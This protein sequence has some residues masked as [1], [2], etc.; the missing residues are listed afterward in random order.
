MTLPGLKSIISSG[1]N[2]QR[3]QECSRGF[4]PFQKDTFQCI[5]TNRNMLWAVEALEDCSVREEEGGQSGFAPE[6]QLAWGTNNF[7]VPVSREMQCSRDT[8]PTSHS[9]HNLCNSSSLVWLSQFPTLPRVT[10][11][12]LLTFTGH[13]PNRG[14]TVLPKTV[15]KACSKA[16]AWSR[17]THASKLVTSLLS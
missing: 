1:C 15:Q 12:L 17:V 5:N 6:K 13:K 10:A 9:L 2:Y 7:S 14:G 8:N 16:R 4:I 3:S 11:M